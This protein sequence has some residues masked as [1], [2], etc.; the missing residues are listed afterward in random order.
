M[1]EMLVTNTGGSPRGVL[2]VAGRVTLAPGES[3][4]LDVDSCEARDASPALRFGGSVAADAT[5]PGEGA[6]PLDAMDLAAL[7]T[8]AARRGVALPA[9]RPTKAGVIAAIHAAAD[10]GATEN[11]PLA[12]MTDDELRATV[13]ALFGV[14]AEPDADRAALL[15]LARGE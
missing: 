9:G 5:E 12:A 14:D 7:K 4:T 13:K 2:T 15:A 6:D 11:D 3:Q 8:E 1:P 10:T